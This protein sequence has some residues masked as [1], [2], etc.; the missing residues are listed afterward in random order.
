MPLE[1]L[2]SET[3]K[4]IY[5]AEKQFMGPLPK[6]AKKAS[7]LHLSRF[8]RPIANRRTA[9]LTANVDMKGMKAA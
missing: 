9:T 7:T 3:L 8:S 6:M 2:F 5:V 4:D 1:D